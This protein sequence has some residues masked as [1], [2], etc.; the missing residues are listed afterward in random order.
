M[1]TSWS[2]PVPIKPNELL[3]SWLTRSALLQGCDPLVLTGYIWPNWRAWIRDVDRGVSKERLLLMSKAS[4]VDVNELNASDLSSIVNA[5]TT[6]PLEK[7]AVWPWVLTQGH[8]NRKRLGGL[9]YC[10][11]C[12]SHDRT[13]YYRKTWRLAWHIGCPL[14][15][16]RL[17]DCCWSC[18]APVQPHQLVAEDKHLAICSNCKKDLREA[19]LIKNLETPILFQHLADSVIQS[20]RGEFNGEFIASHEWFTLSR[21]FLA[22]LRRAAIRPTDNLASML[23]ALG[24]PPESLVIAATG[25]QL[26]MLPIEEREV[27]FAGCYSLLKIT[28][29]GF[30]EAA[31]DY[32][33]TRATLRGV[34]P[35]M[36]E[37]FNVITLSLPI[38]STVKKN[39]INTV[40]KSHAPRSKQAVK[41]MYAR[42]QRRLPT[43]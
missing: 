29:E 24:I 35:S 14:H 43:T 16:I 33:V 12:L 17:H 4:G 21:F 19:P 18:R 34:S 8:R 1:S 3:S 39:K 11:A 30:L 2:L 7:L 32:S 26:E 40:N 6:K 13:P 41:R 31:V 10:S 25:L 42:L 9:Q 5:I 37:S 22:I 27:L 20:K 23:I 28:S 15:N 36:P 38:K